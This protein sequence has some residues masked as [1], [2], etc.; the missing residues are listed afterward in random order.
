MLIIGLKI[1]IENS[2]KGCA[3]DMRADFVR[4]KNDYT[5]DG[6]YEFSKKV[7]ITEKE[8]YNINIYTS[9]RYILKINDKYVCEGP[10]KGHQF[11]KYYDSVYTD[12][13][14]VGEN[15]IKIIVIHTTDEYY[16]TS[17][18][19]S[20]KPEIIF[21]ANSQNN[22][23]ISDESWDCRKNN[24]YEFR[25]AEWRFLPPYE[26][27]DM[28]RGSESF[29]LEK[30]GDFDFLKG[31]ETNYGT[32]KGR[33]LS[34][35]PIDMLFPG[36][37]VDFKVVKSGE[38]FVEL[39]AGKYITAKVYFE[40]LKKADVKI[41]YA[42]RYK[43]SK[44]DK[45]ICDDCS[46]E[47]NGYYDTFKTETGAEYSPFW[48]RTFRFI[49]IES[50]N[51]H[52]ILGHVYAKL[53]HYPLPIEG[54][55]E[56][57]DE[58][59][60]KMY[61]ISVNTMLCCTHDT[62]YDCPYY[63][64][65]Q[66]EMDSA[67]EAAALMRMSSDV[68]MVKKCI[69]EFAA[70]Q[71]PSGLLLSICPATFEQIIPG[72]SFFWIFM[73]YDYLEYTKDIQTAKKLV[74]NIDKIIEYFKEKASSNGLVTKG[75]YWDFVD[76]N[77]AWYQGQPVSVHGKEI[78]VYSMYYAYAL[79]CA[80]KIC[81][82]LNRESL[83]CDYMEEYKIIKQNIKKY[84]FDNK[85]GLYKDSPQDD[86][87]SVHTIIWAI[88]SEIETGDDATN[89]LSRINDEGLIKASFSMKYYLFRAI[90][91]CG[92]ANEIFDNLDGW[93]EMIDMHCTTWREDPRPTVRSECHAW[94]SAPL[95]ECSSNILGVK[96]GFDDEII[97]KPET[98]GLTFAKGTVP[99][100]FGLV[101][102]SWTNDENGFKIE[103]RAPQNVRKKVILPDGEIKMFA[104]SETNI[105]N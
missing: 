7:Y 6:M 35:R 22:C 93:R 16:F 3:K 65:N 60:N 78:T 44:D 5:P 24:Q 86:A 100:R 61:D 85:K 58:Y 15:E 76:W 43:K 18:Y 17:V 47:I 32:S 40:F 45:G 74:G 71:L 98:V 99:T 64:Q 84:C 36:K 46:G 79:L 97:I 33:K 14:N 77:P 37:K 83:A 104:E 63:E 42:E 66:Y 38:D 80:S 67:I 75:R 27:I 55:F 59:L 56:C 9:G 31:I 73:L 8:K 52:E 103:V 69:E 68:K 91:K 23:I 41:I 30:R 34:S 54:S 25:Y 72:Y 62:F 94:S 70:S 12:A 29:S 95:Y 92:K 49:R 19:K 101:N 48:F 89:L 81:R 105:V 28:S 50:K 88:I 26:D 21:E 51:I 13:F 4:A 2:R 11:V 39:D 87:Y 20:K 57:S 102:I 96:V 53:W 10:C 82:M 1:L 90:E